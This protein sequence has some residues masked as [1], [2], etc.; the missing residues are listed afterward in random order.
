MAL[1]VSWAV[2]EIVIG[3]VTTWPA[4]IEKVSITGPVESARG[5]RAHALNIA[6]L[7]AGRVQYRYRV[8]IGRYRW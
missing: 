6:A 5:V 7:R 3:A 4:M 2:A 1:S 8:L